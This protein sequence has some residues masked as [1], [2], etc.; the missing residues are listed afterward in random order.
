MFTSPVQYRN[1]RPEDYSAIEEIEGNE[2]EG[3][4]DFIAEE[5]EEMFARDNTFVSYGGLV[6]EYNS[7]VIGYI[8]FMVPRDWPKLKHIM[9]CIVT[10]D[11][12][13]RGVGSAMLDRVQPTK[14]GFKVSIEIPEEEYGSL[15]FMKKNGYIVTSVQPTEFDEDGEVE[16][17]GYFILANE[18]KEVMELSQ[19]IKWKVK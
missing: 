2:Y 4:D 7:E 15:A 1:I 11:H 9:R 10:S 13:R 19:R 16:L 17:E 12:R 14:T 3:D 5:L 8:I 18:K 6:A